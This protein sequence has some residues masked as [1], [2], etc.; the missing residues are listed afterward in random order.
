MKQIIYILLSVLT[1]SAQA[2]VSFDNVLKEIEIN[3][4]TLKAIARRRM[5]IRL[6]TRQA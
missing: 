6:V 4:T 5:L 2:Q 1:I 3:N